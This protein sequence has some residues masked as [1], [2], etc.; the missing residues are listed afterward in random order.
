MNEVIEASNV[1]KNNNE[2]TSDNLV[3]L[4]PLEKKYRRWSDSFPY[5]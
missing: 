5:D 3:D 2:N 1:G 4:L